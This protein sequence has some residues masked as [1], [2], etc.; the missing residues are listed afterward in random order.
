M[1]FTER[2][3][4]FGR[5][6]LTIK[7]MDVLQAQAGDN[8]LNRTLGP[9]QLTAVG[10]GAIIGT[11]IFVLTGTAAAKFAGPGVV[12]SFAI[13]GLAACF[14]AMSYAELASMIPVAGSAYT[15]TYATMGE[16]AA[17]IIGWDLILEY[18]VGSATVSVGW[19]RYT[20]KFIEHI[21]ST[22]FPTHWTQAPVIFDEKEQVFKVTGDYINL[23][24]IVIVLAITALLVVGIRASTRVNTVAVF[25]KIFA[26][27]LFIFA[28]CGF[29][30]SDNYTPFVPENQ[31]GSKYGAM[32][33]FTGATTVFFAYIGFDAVANTAQ[34]S[35]TQAR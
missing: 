21:F 3:R 28:C 11:G 24:A 7:G 1:P 20:V 30:D 31:G 12:L 13:A 25:I 4:R 27:L 35:W 14:A 22:K 2:L 32:G 9:F 17:W 6:L 26:I 16:F 19:S 23:P 15:Y 18:L 8:Q 29:V 10:I 5:Q 33:V 34:E